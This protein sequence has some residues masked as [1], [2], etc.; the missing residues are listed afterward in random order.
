MEALKSQQGALYP[1]TDQKPWS[2][3]LQGLRRTGRAQLKETYKR[4]EKASLEEAGSYKPKASD[5]S[6]VSRGQE[7]GRLNYFQNNSS[8]Q[9]G[10]IDL[11][12]PSSL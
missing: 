6:K 9:Q 2:L 10:G 12:T 4:P 7:L 5:P 1:Q 11:K 8:S 3:G